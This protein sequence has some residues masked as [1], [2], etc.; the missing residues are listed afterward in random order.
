MRNLGHLQRGCLRLLAEADRGLTT[1][2]MYHLGH[3][4]SVA[5][6]LTS[7]HKFG[8]VRLAGTLPPSSGD[9]R[10]MRRN[11][12]VITPAGRAVHAERQ[13]AA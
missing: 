11:V 4:G 2:D 5:N 7:L 1:A 13:A 10:G 6:A 9:G 12:W 8:W 3:R